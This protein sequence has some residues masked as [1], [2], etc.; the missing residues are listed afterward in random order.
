[1]EYK[2]VI[3]AKVGDLQDGEM[4]QISVEGGEILLV[5]TG[6]KFSALGARCTH[7][8]AELQKGALCGYRIVCPWH[9][10]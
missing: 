10:A 7:Y 2:E 5:K 6:G 3:I 1:M 4:K 9:Q 8:E